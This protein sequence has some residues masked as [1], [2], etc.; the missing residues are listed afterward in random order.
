MRDTGRP[1]LEARDGDGQLLASAEPTGD[2]GSWWVQFAGHRGDGVV[3][4]RPKALAQLTRLVT[5]I[6]RED[7][8]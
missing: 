2:P 1:R 8:R 7:T 6:T 4:S 5:T 3:C